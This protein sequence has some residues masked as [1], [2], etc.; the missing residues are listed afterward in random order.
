M[1]KLSSSP[2]HLALVLK[3]NPHL[4]PWP[5]GKCGDA[6]TIKNHGSIYSGSIQ[7]PLATDTAVYQRRWSVA[8]E[9]TETCSRSSPCKSK[10]QANLWS[11][12]MFPLGLPNSFSNLFPSSLR[13]PS[14]PLERNMSS[15]NYYDS[16][17]NS[18]WVNIEIS[19]WTSQNANA[20]S[21]KFKGMM[22]RWNMNF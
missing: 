1:G 21:R 19:V 12:L 13:F 2:G 9:A 4:T 5:A 22:L 7:R 11:K 3:Y 14:V 16:I 6:I 17:K 8:T 20:V 15:S 18:K 10:L